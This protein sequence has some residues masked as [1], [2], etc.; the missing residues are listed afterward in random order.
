MSI[1]ARLR[2]S[3]TTETGRR[4]MPEDTAVSIRED[5]LAGAKYL[6]RP[7]VKFPG[8]PDAVRGGGE[9]ANEGNDVDRRQ[10][11][12][13]KSQAESPASASQ[14]LRRIGAHPER[15]PHGPVRTRNAVAKQQINRN[16]QREDDL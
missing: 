2:M 13:A 6:I 5:I 8:H 12:D 3:G 7:R 16:P 9:L 14:R 15:D 11:G 4:A 1:V 10:F